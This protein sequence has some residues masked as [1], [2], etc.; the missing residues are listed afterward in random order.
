MYAPDL[1]T[2]TGHPIPAE[3]EAPEEFGADVFDAAVA[4]LRLLG[5][6]TRLRLL[7]HLRD[8]ELDV[9]ALTGALDNA[10][11]PAV[12]QHLAKLRLAGLV[13]TRRDGRRVLYRLNGAHVR[14]LVVE[15]LAQAEHLIASGQAARSRR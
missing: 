13:T 7:W 2:P 6:E 3:P 1:R 4:A 15:S 8:D 14:R 9:T 5:D 12:S 10:A 11:R